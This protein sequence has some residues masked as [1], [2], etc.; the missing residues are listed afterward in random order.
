MLSNLS[1]DERK[2]YYLVVKKFLSIMINPF[3]YLET[4]IEAKNEGKKIVTKWFK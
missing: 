4:I 3:E 2:I 1:N